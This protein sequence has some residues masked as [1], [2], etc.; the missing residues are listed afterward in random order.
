MEANQFQHGFVDDDLQWYE[1]KDPEGFTALIWRTT[2]IFQA[3]KVNVSW[4]SSGRL[5]RVKH[6][7]TFEAAR[8]YCLRATNNIAA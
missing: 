6:F 3:W 2:S 5:L 1:D 7:E 4:T 8:D